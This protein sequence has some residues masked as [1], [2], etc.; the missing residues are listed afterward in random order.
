MLHS[1]WNNRGTIGA[2]VS[3]IAPMILADR[4][5]AKDPDQPYAIKANYLYELD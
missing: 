5:D 1:A 4:M 3:R 2:I